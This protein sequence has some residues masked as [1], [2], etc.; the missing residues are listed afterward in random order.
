ML[1]AGAAVN[2]GAG[3][4]TGTPLQRAAAKGSTG[5][6]TA[7]IAGGADVNAADSRGFTALHEAVGAGCTDCVSLL[8]KAG[9]AVNALAPFKQT[10]LHMAGQSACIPALRVLLAAGADVTTGRRGHGAFEDAA[11]HAAR[12]GSHWPEVLDCFCNGTT[13]EELRHTPLGG[14]AITRGQSRR[15][16]VLTTYVVDTRRQWM[17][18]GFDEES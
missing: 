11:A 4:S 6:I 17:L 8:L 7:L 3:S 16:D 13:G 5:A 9:A 1:D 15:W 2:A 14:R 10:A 18:G 12:L